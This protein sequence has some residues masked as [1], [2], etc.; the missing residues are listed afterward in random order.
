MVAAKEADGRE[1]FEAIAP[2]ANAAEAA[3]AKEVM[4][5][6]ASM[7]T[8]ITRDPPLLPN[9]LPQMKKR[10]RVWQ[11]SRVYGL[12]GNTVRAGCAVVVLPIG[13]L[14]PGP[15]GAAPSPSWL[16]SYCPS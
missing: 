16:A 4:P 2:G 7:R 5:V 11:A 8:R 6:K 12:D 3:S 10:L 9:V 1:V 13:A 14:V 15:N